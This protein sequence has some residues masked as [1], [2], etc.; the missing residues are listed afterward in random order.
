MAEVVRDFNRFV[1]AA[2]RSQLSSALIEMS[3]VVKTV[4]GVD[5]P[6]IARWEVVQPDRGLPPFS[7]GGGFEQVV[8]QAVL[9]SLGS[10]EVVNPLRK[11]SSAL[12][13]M[14]RSLK[15]REVLTCA[16]ACII[17]AI[18]N[19]SVKRSLIHSGIFAVLS[20]RKY[21]QYKVW[22]GITVGKLGEDSVKMSRRKARKS[23][24]TARD[25]VYLPRAFTC[26]GGC[27]C[28]PAPHSVA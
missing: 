23:V 20:F 6:V 21:G 9:C 13:K 18:A 7:I 14:R 19:A 4:D 28:P 15:T 17:S 1:V 12:E 5:A 27:K 25:V 16:H 10:E 2:K 26:F 24:W 11:V 8:G 22:L 3:V